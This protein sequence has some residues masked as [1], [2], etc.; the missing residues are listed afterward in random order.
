M[1]T[2]RKPTTPKHVP[3]QEEPLPLDLLCNMAWLLLAK[4]DGEGGDEMAWRRCLHKA[5][6]MIREAKEVQAWMIMFK[7]LEREESDRVSKREDAIFQRLTPAE[8]EERWVAYERGCQIITGLKKKQD[9]VR[10]FEV[11][12]AHTDIS[13]RRTSQLRL[14]GFP[15]RLVA[16]CQEIFESWDEEIRKKFRKA[17]EKS[18]EYTEDAIKKR[19]EAKKVLARSGRKIA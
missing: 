18:G 5:D 12:N 8:Q 13:E 9:A 17:Y 15:L 11:I 7:Q 3:R 14:A 4:D 19:R 2:P 16:E 1:K 6:N 10:K